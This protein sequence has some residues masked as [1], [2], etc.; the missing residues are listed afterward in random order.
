VI[1]HLKKGEETLLKD[2]KHKESL[3]KRL[4]E[5]QAIEYKKEME[6]K[7]LHEILTKAEQ[8]PI[9]LR[10]QGETTQKALRTM[11][12]ELAELVSTILYTCF[13]CIVY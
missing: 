3:L 5:V 8:E 4:T 7:E 10:R 12:A 13:V 6:N 2:E 9:R 1:D 11:N